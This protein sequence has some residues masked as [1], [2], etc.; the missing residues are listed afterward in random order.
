ML[1]ISALPA[2]VLGVFAGPM[3]GEFGWTLGSFQAGTLIYTFGV[4]LCSPLIGILCDRHGARAVACIGMPLSAL[5][6]AGF[7]FVQ[8][9]VWSWYAAML[10]AAVLSSGTMPAVW[11]RMVNA[12]FVERRG[13]ALGLVLSGSGLFALFGAPFAQSLIENL[14][15]RAAWVGLALLPLMNVDFPHGLCCACSS[16]VLGQDKPRQD[17]ALEGR[18][19]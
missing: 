16:D 6:I 13:L 8:P 2:F 7:A 18:C 11:T 14:G 12:L 19:Q 5:G 10:V 1:G 4:L 3:T 9:S 15:W 17:I